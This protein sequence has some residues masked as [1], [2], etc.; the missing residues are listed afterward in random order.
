MVEPWMSLLLA[1][2]SPEFLSP[3][4]AAMSLEYGRIIQFRAKKRQEI[5]T[6][7]E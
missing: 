5:K 3:D 2:L 7:G 4:A 1:I 6:Y